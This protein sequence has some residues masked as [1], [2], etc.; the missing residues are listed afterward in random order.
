MRLFQF[1]A[2]ILFLPSVANGRDVFQKEVKPLLQSHCFKCHGQKKQKGDLR[3]DTL[4]PNIVQGTSAERWHD[5][6][7]NINLGEMPPEDEPQFSPDERRK[8]V[9]WLTEELQKAAKARRGNGE[10]LV[11]RRLNRTEYQY[12]MMDLLGLEMDYSGAFPSDGRSSEGFKNNG[13]SL[14]MTA[15]QIENYIKIA[16]QAFRFVLVEGEQEKKTVTVVDRN[17]GPIRGPNSRRFTG[18]SSERLG[19]VN[20]WHGSFKD[21]PRTGKFSIRVKAY[22]DR[23]PGQPAPILFAQYGY[24]VSGLT[25]NIM[26]KAGEVTINSGN[27]EYYEI[28]GR[29]EFFPLPE[30]HVPSAKLNGIITLQNALDDGEPIT[31]AVN[32]V[33]EEKDKKGKIRK[34]KVKVF[35]EDPNFPRIIIESVEF[36]RNDYQSWPP[37]LHRRI[38]HEGEDVSDPK[39]VEN[40]LSRFLRRAWRRPVNGKEIK[41]WM[42]H[43]QKMLQQGDSPILA[44]KETLSATLASSNFLYLSE[45]FNSDESRKLN[46][47]ELAARLSYFLWSSMPDE[48]LFKLADSGRLLEPSVLRKQFDRMLADSKADRFAEQFSMQWLDLEGVDRVAVNPQY[49]KGFDNK[50]KPDMV[51]ETQAFFREILSSNTSALQFIDADFTML[52]ASLAKH[53]GLEGPKSQRFERVSLKGTSRPG[54]VLGHASTLLAGSD[55]AD[56]HPIKRAVWIRERL[57]NDPPNP[58]PPDVPGVE[59]SVPN[60]EKLSIREQLAIH[61]KKEACADCHRGIDPWGIA[62]EEYDA[63]GLFREK[64][65]RRKERVSAETV[66]PGSHEISGLI[67]LQKHLLN[68][69]RDQFAKALVSKLLTYALGRS[70]S[71]EDELLIEKLSRDFATNDY[72]LPSLMKNIVTSRPFLSR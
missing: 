57:L 67:D 22:T 30:S 21:L 20:F 46:A 60:F 15:L 14:S 28:P 3:L 12:T 58:P 4:D 10:Q 48:E 29:P 2:L 41:K 32:K 47:H 39:V 64:T 27:P 66:L 31:Q 35:P 36:V 25:L 70:L 16:R 43:Y 19:R 13:A 5:V 23:K 40:L 56:S 51:G 65:A 63:I 38:L 18:N 17:K 50:L 71:L 6:L 59:K 68:G 72:R 49:Y 9:G 37:A 7:N 53:Y 44:L 11:M 8:L 34:R 62:L 42:A 26:G 61:R 45:P 33:I 54:G 69:R 55:G 1:A 52:N 24:F